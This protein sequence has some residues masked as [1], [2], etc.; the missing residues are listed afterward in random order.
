MLSIKL[1][2][3]CFRDGSGSDFRT[4]FWKTTLKACR[5]EEQ[6][7][8]H[9]HKCNE[10]GEPQRQSGHKRR[11]ANGGE[12]GGGRRCWGP[13][14]AVPSERTGTW[15]G[16]YSGRSWWSKAETLWLPPVGNVHEPR[17]FDAPSLWPLWPAEGETHRKWCHQRSFTTKCGVWEKP[18]IFTVSYSLVDVSDNSSEKTLTNPGTDDERTQQWQELF[19]SWFLVMLFI[20]G[21]EPWVEHVNWVPLH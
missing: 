14:T 11:G 21:T 2:T 16:F 17:L 1:H 8:W 10:D 7:K 4:A 5:E 15:D 3:L 6:F 20:Q 13:V 19:I 12:R 18:K 9:L